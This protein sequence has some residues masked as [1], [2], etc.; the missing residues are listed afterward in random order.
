[1]EDSCCRKPPSAP[2]KP[3]CPSCGATG[4][5][6]QTTTV[7]SLTQAARF[8]E[9]E[10]GLHFCATPRCPVVYFDDAGATLSESDLRVPV[11]QKRGDPTVPV[12]YCFGWSEE[13]IRSEIA[14]TGRSTAVTSISARVKAGDCACE[15]KNPQGSCCLGN[16]SQVVK[17]GKPE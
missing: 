5:P 6:V 7:R 3:A 1:M 13:R 17:N 14:D 9:G 12:C 4:K 8:P 2:L 11:W 10:I 16:V 15:R